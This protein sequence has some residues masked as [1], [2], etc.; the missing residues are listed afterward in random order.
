MSK[1]QVY[2]RM[3]PATILNGFWARTVKSSSLKANPIDTIETAKAMVTMLGVNPR[4][5]WLKEG[6]GARNGDHC[7]EIVRKAFCENA[8]AI[9]ECDSM[10]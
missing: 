7:G 1:K 8:Q 6:Y 2:C 4:K 3:T 10:V 9:P 5:G